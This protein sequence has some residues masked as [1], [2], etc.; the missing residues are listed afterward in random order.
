MKI[1]L[2][3]ALLTFFLMESLQSIIYTN[4]V[5]TEKLKYFYIVETDLQAEE[6]SKVFCERL[7]AK[8]NWRK[9]SAAAGDKGS[10]KTILSFKTG[11]HYWLCEV[12]IKKMENEFSK[13]SVEMILN[14]YPE[15]SSIF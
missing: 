14:T 1:L 3:I 7:S 8:H 10:Y 11:V 13:M 2:S 4:S 9:I 15:D 5:S 12:T 6:F